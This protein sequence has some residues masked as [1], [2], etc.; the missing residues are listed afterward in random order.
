M[1]PIL[2]NIF[3]AL[4][5]AKTR[6]Q[7]CKNRWAYR[8]VTMV[9]DKLIMQWFILVIAQEKVGPDNHKTFVSEPPAIMKQLLL[10]LQ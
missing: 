7:H 3:R 1:I 6:M 5:R 9:T 10:L 4:G 8:V 2:H